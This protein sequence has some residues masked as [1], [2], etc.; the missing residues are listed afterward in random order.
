MTRLSE[1]DMSVRL[2]RDDRCGRA[3]VVACAMADKEGCLKKGDS[4]SDLDCF[5][6]TST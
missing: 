2:I 3:A 1:N 6:D 4:L 5:A